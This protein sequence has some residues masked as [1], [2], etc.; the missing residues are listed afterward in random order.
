MQNIYVAFC[1]FRHPLESALVERALRRMNDFYA[2][3]AVEV[4]Q[5]GLEGRIGGS[6][7]AARE[8]Q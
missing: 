5:I 6:R 1:E 3:D 8:G 7:V 2:F 4:W